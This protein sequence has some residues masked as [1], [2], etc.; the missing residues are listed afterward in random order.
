MVETKI[1][2]KKVYLDKEFEELLDKYE[3]G[4]LGGYAYTIIDNRIVYMHK[5]ILPSES[6][7]VTDHRD[8]NRL[9]N[10]R[11]NLRNVTSAENNYNVEHKGGYDNFTGVTKVKSGKFRADTQFRRNKIN[12]GTYNTSFEAALAYDISVEELRGKIYCSNVD[13]DN[14]YIQMIYSKIN[15]DTTRIAKILKFRNIQGDCHLLQSNFIGVKIGNKKYKAT[16]GIAGKKIHLGYYNQEKTAAK[17]YD[18]FLIY[19]QK[20]TKLNYPEYEE[21]YKSIIKKYYYK[22]LLLI[23]KIG[24]FSRNR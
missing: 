1:K 18:L 22:F 10:C 17:I 11:S 24:I 19:N 4:L 5:L 13:S 23:L 20:K 2:G 9:N 16:I 14:A 7:K 21:I 3:W 8:R 15:N 6:G 12:L